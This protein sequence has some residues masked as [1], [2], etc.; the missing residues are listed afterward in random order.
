MTIIVYKGYYVPVLWYK[1]L[2][3]EVGQ[4]VSFTSKSKHYT[5]IT[6]PPTKCPKFYYIIYALKEYKQNAICCQTYFWE[7]K[8]CSSATQS[9]SYYVWTKLVRGRTANCYLPFHD[10]HEVPLL[11]GVLDNSNNTTVAS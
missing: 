3:C 7:H 2:S 11:T 1:N 6:P 8:R 4:L 9:S 10:R 5:N